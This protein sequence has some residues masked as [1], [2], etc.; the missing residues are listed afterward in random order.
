MFFTDHLIVITMEGIH[1]CIVS[2]PHVRR[3]IKKNDFVADLFINFV[4][5]LFN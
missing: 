4:A 2:R 1:A 5:D 3:V